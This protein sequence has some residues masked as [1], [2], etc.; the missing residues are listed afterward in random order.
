MYQVSYTTRHPTG[1]PEQLWAKEVYLQDHWLI[2]ETLS[3]AQEQFKEIDDCNNDIHC[4]NISKIIEASEPH[5]TEE[6]CDNE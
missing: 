6:D 3:K 2:C 1:K 4:W 5:W